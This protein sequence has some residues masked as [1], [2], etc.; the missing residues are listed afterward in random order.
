MQC[1]EEPRDRDASRSEKRSE[2][3]RH[4]ER[5]RELRKTN[6]KHARS[7]RQACTLRRFFTM[8]DAETA[9]ESSWQRTMTRDKLSVYLGLEVETPRPAAGG[10]PT[11]VED[12]QPVQQLFPTV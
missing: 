1:E 4:E 6:A 7:W 8:T 2:E 12:Q 3:I 11:V 9:L 10:E 5:S